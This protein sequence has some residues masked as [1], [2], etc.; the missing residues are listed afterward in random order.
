MSVI[1]RPLNIPT[2]PKCGRDLELVVEDRNRKGQVEI[3]LVC[4]KH[5]TFPS[6]WRNNMLGSLDR[7]L[8]QRR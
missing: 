7:Q 8:K 6:G 4:A 3:S 1:E 5:G 2:C